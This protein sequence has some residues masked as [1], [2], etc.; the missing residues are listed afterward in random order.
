MF[1]A[2]QSVNH[3]IVK[4][5]ILCRVALLLEQVGDFAIFSEASEGLFR[6]EAGRIMK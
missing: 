2:F 5:R 6:G 1:H 3:T 4:L